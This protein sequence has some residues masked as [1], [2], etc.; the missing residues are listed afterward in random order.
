MTQHAVQVKKLKEPPIDGTEEGLEKVLNYMRCLDY[1]SLD[2]FIRKH[3]FITK[4]TTVAHEECEGY[5]DKEVSISIT[6]CQKCLILNMIQ[7]SLE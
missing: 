7:Y 5:H 4:I 2:L 1:A 3:D 6:Y